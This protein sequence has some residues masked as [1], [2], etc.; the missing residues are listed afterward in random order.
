[1]ELHVGEVLLLHQR[2]HLGHAV[3]EGLG[4]DEGHV[5]MQF[6][7]MR[8]VLAAAEADFQPAPLSHAG[9]RIMQRHPE[10]GQQLV[11]EFGMMTAQGFTLAPPIELE[12][13]FGVDDHFSAAL[14]AFTRSIFS[15]EK[16]PSFSG[17]RPKW[18]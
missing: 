8:Q 1:M 13:L 12:P 2:Q 7:L 3:D 5:R 17:A 18:P 6:R 14:S 15:Q 10:V 16:P 11:H 9:Q 4:P